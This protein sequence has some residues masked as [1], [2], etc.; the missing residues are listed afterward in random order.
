MAKFRK[1]K[2]RSRR[3]KRRKRLNWYQRERG[4]IRL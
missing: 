4:G 1:F 2:R 3:P